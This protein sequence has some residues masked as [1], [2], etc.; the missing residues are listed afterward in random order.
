MAGMPDTL[1]AW[2]TRYLD[3]PKKVEAQLKKRPVLLYDPPPE[4]KGEGAIGEGDDDDDYQFRTQSG[5]STPAIGGGDPM[6]VVVE[7]TKDNAFQRRIT[8]GRTQNNDIVLE[9]A[10]VSRFHC[11]LQEDGGAWHLSDAGSRNG[12]SVAGRR[13]AAKSPVAVSSGTKVK[14]GA[15][16]LTFFSAEGFLAYLKKRAA[17]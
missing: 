15:V 17:E 7:K 9:D 14:V 8:I 11:W 5:I 6:A 16:E 12:T 3:D 13:L 1:L 4:P 2:Y 10:S